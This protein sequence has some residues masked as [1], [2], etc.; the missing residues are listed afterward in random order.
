MMKL[1]RMD[2]GLHG[3]WLFVVIYVLLRRYNCMFILNDIPIQMN[4]K[5][6]VFFSKEIDEI[7]YLILYRKNDDRNGYAQMNASA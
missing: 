2:N 5:N 7:A 4:E 1:E 3:H 6:V